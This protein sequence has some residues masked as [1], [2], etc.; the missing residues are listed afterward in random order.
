MNKVE[1]ISKAPSGRTRRSPLSRK[2]ILTVSGKEDGYE[3]RIVNDTEDRVS[4]F[5]D[6]G[7]EVVTQDKVEVGDKRVGKSTPEGTV[8][9]MSVGGGRKGIVMR[10]P[11]EWYDEDQK[12]KQAH[13]AETERSATKEATKGTYG[14]LKVSRD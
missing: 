7:Y 6:A 1:A 9:Q 5:I 12:A 4:Q 2:N 11:K 3:Y 13:V 10:I 14:D 8:K